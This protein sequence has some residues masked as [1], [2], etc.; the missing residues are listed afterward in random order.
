[1]K[2]GKMQEG[3]NRKNTEFKTEGLILWSGTPTANS[4][5]DAS[6]PGSNLAEG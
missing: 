6:F 3:R 4:A 2:C 1:M 5:V